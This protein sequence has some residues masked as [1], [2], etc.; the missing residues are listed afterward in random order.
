MT[1]LR[2]LTY[3]DE[4]LLV[5]SEPIAEMTDD[6]RQLIADMA[7]TMYAAKGAGLA[8][9]QVG[10]AGRLFVLDVDQV[11]ENGQKKRPRRLRVYINPNIIETSKEDSP[12]VEGCLSIPGIEMEIYRPARIR[13]HYRDEQWQEHEEEIEGLLARVIQHESDHLDGVLFVDRLGFVKRQ[14]LAAQL[15]R[16][17]N[18]RETIVVPAALTTDEEKHPP[19]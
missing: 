5:R 18:E 12:Y 11:D 15:R 1:L 7:E 3:G 6:L 2:V 10:V 8:A 16:L 13:L 4:R 17:R 19:M 14:T 9:P